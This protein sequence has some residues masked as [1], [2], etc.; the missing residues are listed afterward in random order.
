MGSMGAYGA[1]SLKRLAGAGFAA[2]AMV[3]VAIGAATPAAAAEGQV[4]YAGSADSI[5]DN[6]VIVFKDS[7]S[8][9]SV[10]SHVQ[11]STARYGGAGTPPLPAAPP[12]FAPHPTH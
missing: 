3:A 1:G 5:Q 4:L 8:A 10:D 12:R 2:A 7:V 9:A 6:Y 11:A